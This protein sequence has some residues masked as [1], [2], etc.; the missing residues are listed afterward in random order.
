MRRPLALLLMLGVLGQPVPVAAE[1]FAARDVPGGGASQFTGQPDVWDSLAGMP[2][3]TRCRL[4]LASGS[5]IT[6]RLV[7]AR[8][9]AIV[10][11]KNEVRKG[12]FSPP[13]GLS[14]K[15]PLT[16]PRSD[17]SLVAVDKGW[18]TWAKVLLWV[19][20]GWV[21]AGAIIGSIVGNS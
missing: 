3:G 14:L 17:V 8:A 15:D 10:L 7:S 1:R 9:D 19:G 6:G 11:E 5:E 21:A 4:V 16:F 18:P 2:R 12:T 20:I 13:S